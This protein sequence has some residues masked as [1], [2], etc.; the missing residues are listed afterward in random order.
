MRVKLAE[1]RRL[2]DPYTKTHL[3]PDEVRE[4]PRNAYWLRRLRDGDVVEAAEEAP[5]QRQ[6]RPEGEA[7]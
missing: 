3:E 1:G 4:V 5:P 7:V 6:R 2:R